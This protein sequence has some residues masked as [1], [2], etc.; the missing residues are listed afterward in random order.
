[1]TDSSLLTFALIYALFV[2]SPGPGIAA[3]VARGLGS[4]FHR[5]FGFI[6]GFALG[7]MIWFAI[8]GTGLSALAT[9]FETAFLVFKYLGCL[10]LL[11]MAYRLWSAPLATSDVEAKHNLPGQF[12]AFIGSLALTLSNP[13]VIVFFL[14]LMPLIVDVRHVTPSSFIVL[15]LTAGTVCGLSLLGVLGLATQA[16]RVFRSPQA[17]R[18]INRGSAGMMA[19]AAVLIGLKS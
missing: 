1:M 8:A 10:Y 3:V 7:D 15:V 14:S 9:R 18:R 11:Y 19:G 12:P 2:L 6:A 4:G 5:S 16:R 17:L 13:K